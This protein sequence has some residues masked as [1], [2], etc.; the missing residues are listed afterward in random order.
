[1]V[2]FASRQIPVLRHFFSLIFMPHLNVFLRCCSFVVL[3]QFI[4]GITEDLLYSDPM[5][6]PL[7]N[8]SSPVKRSVQTSLTFPHG[9]IVPD[10]CHWSILIEVILLVSARKPCFVVSCS[11]VILCRFCIFAG[12]F[13]P[14]K[15]YLYVAF[16]HSKSFNTARFYVKSYLCYTMVCIC[17]LQFIECQ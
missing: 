5:F 10:F 9:I 12:N 13:S 2:A 7:L 6:N 4:V 16:Y 15:Q 8:W 1:M 3:F 17:I 14:D 11:S